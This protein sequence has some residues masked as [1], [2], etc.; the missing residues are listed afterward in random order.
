MTTYRLTGSREGVEFQAK[1]EADSEE[2][3][4]ETFMDEVED[5]DEF[6]IEEVGVWT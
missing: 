5:E 6:S 3:A 1:V 4:Q 2:S